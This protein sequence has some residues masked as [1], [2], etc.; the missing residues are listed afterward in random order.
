[1]YEKE[2]NTMELIL[3]AI[4]VIVFGVLGAVHLVYTFILDTARAFKQYIKKSFSN[5]SAV[6]V[7]KKNSTGNSWVKVS[8]NHIIGAM[9]VA[10]LFVSL[11]ITKMDVILET[12]WLLILPEIIE[13][14]LFSLAKEF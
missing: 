2:F 8:A 9:L 10:I 1:M 4:G 14:P 12:Q 7:R 13:S 11:T 3:L 5:I 6:L